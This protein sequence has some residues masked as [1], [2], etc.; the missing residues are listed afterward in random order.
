MRHPRMRNTSGLPCPALPVR[1]S[2][3]WTLPAG[4][5]LRSCIK[6]PKDSTSTKGVDHWPRQLRR[7]RPRS[8]P[9]PARLDK[10][11]ATRS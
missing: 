11:A 10:P 6:E 5:T 3:E 9:D 2:C 8:G 7:R 1:R 4:F